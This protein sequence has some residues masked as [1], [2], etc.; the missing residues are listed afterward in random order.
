MPSSTIRE[1]ALVLKAKGL[2]RKT[3]VRIIIELLL[4]T[5]ITLGG[6]A[7]FLLSD[8]WFQ[9][10]TALLVSTIGLLGVATNT[11]TSAHGA[12]SDSKWVNHALTYFGYP[13]ML[14]MSATYWHHKHN[15]I[16]H[17]VPNVVGE[18][19]DVDLSPYFALTSDQV[20]QAS[21]W[22][23][24]WYKIQWIFFPLA[25]SANGFNVQW[26]G[27][28]YLARQLLDPEIRATK[29]WLD[30]AAMLLHIVT[31]IIVPALFFGP[32][33]AVVWYMARIALMGYAMFA[34][35]APAH[36]P[37]AAPAAT[38]DQKDQDY[39][40]IQTV[41]TIDFETGAIGRFLCSG[42]DYQIEHHLFPYIS[43]T[44]YPAVAPIVKDYCESHG[45]PYRCLPWWRAIWQ[46]L[47][48]MKHPKPVVKDLTMYRIESKPRQHF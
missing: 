46:S 41:N 16:H 6:F 38:Q 28:N 48:V 26:S 5:A 25:L 45:Y 8:S 35:F 22:Q 12:T 15:M 11:H 31:W 2:T 21:I 23:K 9:T 36:F 18:D 19:D 14:M 4:H 13:Y 24:R 1:L 42:V 10:A 32:V 43:H 17:P 30:L 3:P 47:T 29:H 39:V 34:A 20:K 44:Q 40:L 7:W 33:N 37:A 27:W